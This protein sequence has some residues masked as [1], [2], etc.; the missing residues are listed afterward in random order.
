MRSAVSCSGLERRENHR[1]LARVAP[2]G[3]GRRAG[4]GDGAGAR[5]MAGARSCDRRRQPL[6]R[7]VRR[8]RAGRA[9]RRWRGPGRARAGRAGRRRSRCATCPYEGAGGGPRGSGAQTT[10]AH[11]LKRRIIKL[12]LDWPPQQLDIRSASRC[13]SPR[14]LSAGGTS[15]R[16]TPM[17]GELCM[18]RAEAPT[19]RTRSRR[20][21]ACERICAMGYPACRA[22]RR[23]TARRWPCGGQNMKPSD[24]P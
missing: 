2:R 19:C 9:G 5:A 13:S 14:S 22:K 8:R 21:K 11:A 16:A 17:P 24:T 1:P 6:A 15:A 4:R 3:V 7:A 12:H 18:Q 23:S 10:L 20:I